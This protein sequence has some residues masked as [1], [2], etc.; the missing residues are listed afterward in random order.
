MA[1]VDKN[2]EELMMHLGEFG[3]Y[4]CWQFCLHILGALT[5]GL[6]MLTLLTVA[7]VP[8]HT[9]NVPRSTFPT[10]SFNFTS[11]TWNS[12][13]AFDDVPRAVD[14]CHYLDAN[15]VTKE[16]DSWTYDTEYFQSSRGMEWNFVCSQRWMGAAAQSCYMFGVFIGAVTLGSLADKYG[17]KIIFYVSAVAQLVFGVTVALVNKYYLFLILRFLYGIF[18]SAGAYITGFVLT[19]E[20]V[21]AT[22]R[23]VCGIMFQLAFAVGFMLVAVWGAVIKD[24][25]WLQIVYG[26]HSVLLIGHWWLMDESPRWLWAQGRVSEA[27]TIIRKG[28]KMNGNNVDIDTG[29][30]ISEG[31]IRQMDQEEQGSYGALDLFKTP[32]LRK[33]TLNVCLNWFANSIVY[34]GLSLNA[35]NLVGNPFLMLFLSGLVELPSYLLMCFLMDRTGR[36][37]LVS[38]F[39]LI[40]GVCCII[41]SSI[42]TGTDTAATI[43]VTIVL[44]GKACIAGS[45]AVIYNYTAELFPTVVR[46]TALGIGSMCARFSGALTPLIMLLDSL[47]PKVPA[48]LFG[49]V[50]LVSGF[51]SLYLPETV[52]QPMPETIEDGENFG[53]H[54]TCFAMYLRSGRKTSAAYEATQLTQ[55]TVDT[56][57]KEK[58]NEGGSPKENSH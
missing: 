13:I 33:K 46:N 11:S 20:L 55:L 19:M 4:Q 26:L 14:A 41:A 12:S 6:H 49:F 52:N 24:R 16:C 37:C 2:L 50:A 42:P 54:D 25:T 57:E 48:V 51:L 7:A 31:K 21:G 27:L 3:K 15:N 35:G 38:T 53:K 47:N 34:Y 28:L 58:L 22:K 5:A 40:G 8:P 44:F 10:E 17:R 18:G 9:C 23:T 29:K 45:F 1:S 56:D 30:L 36:R 39:M 43:I 32:N